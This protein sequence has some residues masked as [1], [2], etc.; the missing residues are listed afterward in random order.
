MRLTSFL[1]YGA[2]LKERLART[3]A[4]AGRRVFHPAVVLLFVAEGLVILARNP[5]WQDSDGLIGALFSLQHMTLFYWGQD[6][7]ANVVPA[8]ATAFGNPTVNVTAQLVL[9]TASGVIAPLFACM[10]LARGVRDAWLATLLS[11]GLFLMC[12][13]HTMQHEAFIQAS[14]YGTSFALA[15]IALLMFRRALN[16]RPSSATL[17]QLGATICAAAAYFVNVSL[18]LLTGPI[19]LGEVLLFGSELALVFGL[20]SLGGL[21]LCLIAMTRFA[22]DTPTP[23]GFA[24][25]DAGLLALAG[26]MLGKPGRFI[27]T[28]LGGSAIVYLLAGR[29]RRG[30]KDA[31]PAAHA[32]L[33]AFTLVIS[34]VA[35]SLS[36]WVVQNSSHPRYLLPAY[37]LA[38]SI[39]GSALFSFTRRFVRS[40]DALA[41]AGSIV[42]LLATVARPAPSPA[43]G[44]I[45]PKRRPVAEAVAAVVLQ[46]SLDGVEGDYWDVWPAVFQSEQERYDAGLPVGRILGVTL[47]GDARRAAFVA[48]LFEKG[49]LDIA[50]IDPSPGHCNALAVATMRPPATEMRV[51]MP[52][53]RLPD[54]RLLS[55]LT[56]ELVRAP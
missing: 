36:T 18:V 38:A 41:V 52:P 29:G 7:F 46:R 56:I 15:G 39:G 32:A 20:A 6:R 54:G 21:A 44:M 33:A 37:I 13:P 42:L 5:V 8:L 40:G 28:M 14:P 51:D 55:F 35:V 27:L 26:E 31:G 10:F 16:V 17:W 30:G 47:R 45:D 50:C 4:A 53:V 43:S 23:G 24:R 12:A 1:R 25:T 2:V 34:A 9:R 48:R 3:V 11:T 22:G 19:L 49:R